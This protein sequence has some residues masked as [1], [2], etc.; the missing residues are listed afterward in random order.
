MFFHPRNRNLALGALIEALLYITQRTRSTGFQMLRNLEEI[1]DHC[2]IC[3]RCLARCPVKIDSGNIT[4]ESREIL[5]NMHF[6][7]TPV[8]T[9][10]TLGYLADKRP[11]T[12][13]MTRPLLLNAGTL[14]QRTGAALMSPVTGIL[15]FS[16]IRSAQVLQS[17][18]P[19]PDLTTLRAHVPMTLK[20]QA[21]VLEPKQNAV[22]TV[23]YFPGCGSERLFSRISRAAIYILLSQHHR[24]I[25]PPPFLCCGYPFLVNAR[26]RKYEEL[27]LKNIMVLTQMREMFNDLS[28]DA[29]VVSCGTCMESLGK[30]DVAR[31]F[32]GPVTDVSEYVLKDWHFSDVPASACLYHAPCHDSLKDRGTALLKNQGLAVTPV[33]HC[34]SQAGTMAL[35]RPDISHNMLV[36]KQEA[37]AFSD[38]F[39]RSAPIKILT[40]CPS[41]VQG[42]GRLNGVKPV[43]LAEELAMAMGG[44]QWKEKPLH[45]WTASVEMVTF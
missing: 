20:N 8:S 18:M 36:R 2:T 9:R 43:H 4:I 40:N 14:F 13:R 26:T 24:V 27:V 25:L 33:P 5:K 12:N 7:H 37:L 19:W 10:I 41:S 1:A 6:K 32:D 28:F 30:L 34:C 22:S 21:L 35:S 42:L 39:N 15:P 29:V 45:E 23:F 44:P 11:L 3:H 38:R 31:I 16:K 17:K